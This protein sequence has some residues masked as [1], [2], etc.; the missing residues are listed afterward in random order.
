M[1][2]LK[3]WYADTRQQLRSWDGIEQALCEA[4]LGSLLGPLCAENACSAQTLFKFAIR[5]EGFYHRSRAQRALAEQ[6]HKLALYTVESASLVEF[7][8]SC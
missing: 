3:R 2:C 5:N 4:A 6:G 1:D 7:F 8:Q